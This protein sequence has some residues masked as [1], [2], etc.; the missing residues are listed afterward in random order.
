MQCLYMHS[1]SQLGLVQNCCQVPIHV[2]VFGIHFPN[3]R[4]SL[5]W[6]VPIERADTYCYLTH[7]NVQSLVTI[8]LAKYQISL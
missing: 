2:T 4:E 3:S 1:H 5:E 7:K 8:A 6:F